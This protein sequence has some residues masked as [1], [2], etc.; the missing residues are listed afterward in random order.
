MVV[1]CRDAAALLGVVILFSLLH[2]HIV[3]GEPCV[4]SDLRRCARQFQTPTFSKP[5]VLLRGGDV[6]TITSLDQVED[7]ITNQ[8]SAA[9]KLVVLDFASNNCTPCEMI[10]PI[11]ADLSDLEEFEGKVW[12]LKVNVSDYPEVAQKYGVDGWPTFLLF[13]D[14]KVVDSVVGGQAAKASLYGLVAKHI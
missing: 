3:C 6:Q 12:F 2:I 11:Y 9:K 5:L 7:I 10:A 14:G 4:F 1:L 8:A 13:K